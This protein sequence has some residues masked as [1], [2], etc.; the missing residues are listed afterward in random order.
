VRQSSSYQSKPEGKG[1]CLT[2]LVGLTGMLGLGFLALMLAPASWL[3]WTPLSIEDRPN[4]MTRWKLAGFAHD[5][6]ACRAF[7]T[8]AG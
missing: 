2:V 8:S 3:P 6:A 1:G 7:L 5:P 4:G